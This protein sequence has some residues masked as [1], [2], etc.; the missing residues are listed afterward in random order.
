MESI[1]CYL[2]L[3]SIHPFLPHSR[4]G[5]EASCFIMCDKIAG[6]QEEDMPPDD[7]RTV[8]FSGAVSTE[9]FR[10]CSMYILQILGL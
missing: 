7:A 2:R 1:V 4:E 5:C 6:C 3:L 10:A 9:A 8:H